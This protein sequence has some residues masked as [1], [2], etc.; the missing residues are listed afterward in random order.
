MCIHC[1]LIMFTL[2]IPPGL[3]LPKVMFTHLLPLYNCEEN[4]FFHT[5]T[6]PSH[7]L[8]AVAFLF[9]FSHLLLLELSSISP[10][11]INT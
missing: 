2:L 1:I 4:F 7:F 11:R 9:C 6:S 3:P 5:V 10:P 8:R